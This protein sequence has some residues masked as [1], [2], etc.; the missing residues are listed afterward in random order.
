MMK[1]MIGIALVGAVS[2]SAQ[3]TGVQMKI[4][5]EK[6][7]AEAKAIGFVTGQIIS[8]RTVKGQP[9]SAQAVNETVQVL[10]DGNRIAHSSTSAI[11]RDSEGRERREESIGGLGNLHNEPAKAIMI[12]DPVTGVNFSLDPNNKIAHKNTRHVVMM[13]SAEPAGVGIGVG[14]A[15]PR[16]LAAVKSEQMTVTYSSGNGEGS[17][18]FFYSTSDVEKGNLRKEEDLGPQIIEGV[19]AVG[20]RVT[21]TI[22]AGQIGNDQAIVIVNERWVSPDLGVTVKSVH[23]DPRQ[24]TTTY[25]LTNI[26]RAEPAHSLFEVP[27]DYKMSESGG[28]TIRRDE[29]R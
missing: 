23:T 24:G 26:D 9:Y 29:E 3:D 25:K 6:K 18:S 4:D 17:N 10:A 22:P 27:P 12:S 11:Y 5:L 20:T 21:T 16:A 28:M 8:D 13:K 19:P 1:Y 15:P 7:M 14:V 2:L